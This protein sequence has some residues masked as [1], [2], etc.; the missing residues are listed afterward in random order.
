MRNEQAQ[1]YEVKNLITKLENKDK[2]GGKITFHQD[3]KR[4]RKPEQIL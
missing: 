2:N 3:S 4:N 1:K